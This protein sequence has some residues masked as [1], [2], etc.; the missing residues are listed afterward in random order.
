MPDA[1]LAVDSSLWNTRGWTFQEKYLSATCIVITDWQAYLTCAFGL[2]QEDM[3]PPHK[4]R[5]VRSDPLLRVHAD[6]VKRMDDYQDV[7]E[8]YTRRGL[9]FQSDILNAFAGLANVIS[10]HLG[11]S[12]LFGMPETGVQEALLWSHAAAP[13]RRKNPV[14]LPSWSW[15]AWLGAMSYSY[16]ARETHDALDC[17]GSLVR[18][19]IVESDGLLRQLDFTTVDK[20]KVDSLAIRCALP[21]RVKVF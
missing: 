20:A 18:F 15:A 19:S 13:E 1:G 6:G 17:I 21:A 9:S 14:G 4:D 16:V 2:V 11:S 8:M 12:M 7:V 5:S 3:H 10:S